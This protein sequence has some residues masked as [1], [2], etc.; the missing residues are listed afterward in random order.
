MKET[1]EKMMRLARLRLPQKEFERFSQK[2][3]H[4]VEYIETL[5]EIDTA[6]IEPTS[7]AIEVTNAFREDEIKPFEGIK[8]ILETA[9]AQH[10]NLF[11]VPKVIE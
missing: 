4:V 9:P 10:E 3:A 2:A 5:K 11:E 6:N 8:K 1:I 7:H